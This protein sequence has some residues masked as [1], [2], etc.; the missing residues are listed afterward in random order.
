MNAELRELLRVGI[1]TALVASGK[2]T[3]AAGVLHFRLKRGGF[4]E[5]TAEELAVELQYLLDKGLVVETDKRISPE[6]KQYR[7]TAEGRDFLAQE[8]LA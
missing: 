5:L 8:G 3:P 2:Y 1:L 6:N 4:P 7:I